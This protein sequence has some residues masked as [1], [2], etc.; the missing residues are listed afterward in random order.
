MRMLALGVVAGLLGTGAAFAS[1]ASAGISAEQNE[2][3]VVINAQQNEDPIIGML[4][5][6]HLGLNLGK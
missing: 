1:T 5:G 2:D 3:P 6:S 4:A